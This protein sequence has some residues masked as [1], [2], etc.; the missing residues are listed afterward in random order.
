MKGA[1]IL[2]AIA[3]VW[4]AVLIFRSDSAKSDIINRLQEPFGN[5]DAVVASI[6]RGLRSHAKTITV[7]FFSGDMIRGDPA[8]MAANWIEDAMAETDNESEGDYIRYQCGGYKIS[9]ARESAGD[10]FFYT[11]QIAPDY[12]LYLAQED[13]ASEKLDEIFSDFAFPDTVSDYEKLLAIYNYICQNVKY[14]ETHGKNPYYHLKS[15][16]Y[17]ALVQG[18]ATC[19]GY[20]VA[21]YRMSR[22]A[23]I[24]C[25][26]VTG[27]GYGKRGEEFHAWNIAK[28]EGLWYSLDATWDAGKT[29]YD[30]FLRG[31]AGF[32]RHI[33]GKSFSGWA[34]VYPLSKEDFK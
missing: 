29:E 28:L 27:T 5:R 24:P 17:A 9:C 6:R 14:D 21:L 30:W 16:A 10:R 23:G 1:R 18:T 11:I 13:A 4:I 32:V 7:T 8:D 33:P 31:T 12:Y 22:R 25:R 2:S 26:I 34:A 15:T 3:S 19:Q 20:S